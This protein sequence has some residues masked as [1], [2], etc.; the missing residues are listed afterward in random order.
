MNVRKKTLRI[1]VPAQLRV[2]LLPSRRVGVFFQTNKLSSAKRCFQHAMVS[3]SPIPGRLRI[4]V[5]GSQIYLDI[6]QVQCYITAKIVTFVKTP[7]D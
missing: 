7:E 5:A 3:R 2:E 4:L 6:L 1:L